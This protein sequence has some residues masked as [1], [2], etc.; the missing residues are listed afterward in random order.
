[1]D[2]LLTI[3]IV[4]YK[5]PEL[6]KICLRL[7]NLHTDLSRVEV[8]VIDNHSED[9]SI[10]WLK[11]LPF[12]KLIERPAMS[13]ERVGESHSRA[14]DLGFEEVKTPLVMVM[15]T[16]TFVMS[17]DWLDVLVKPFEN[18]PNLAG[19]GSWK[20]ES[21]PWWKKIGKAIEDG[22][23]YYLLAPFF[24]RKWGERP[25]RLRNHMFLRSHCAVYRTELLRQYTDG[26]FGGETAGK[27][28]HHQ[29]AEA[30]YELRFIPS[31]E[32]IKYIW[33]LNHATMVLHPEL[34]GKKTSKPS[35]LRQLQ[36]DM[37]KMHYRDILANDKLDIPV[38][39]SSP[40]AGSTP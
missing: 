37:E 12:V 4:Q 31:D 14:L 7:L 13:G 32:L 19:V 8:I 39:R 40:T 24:G 38:T 34:G 30:G 1:M 23:K 9:E 35:S 20:L 29:L 26:F 28:A 5:T 16:D 6:T 22:V 25:E 21:V 11:S 3:L 17:D 10:D 15:H 36:R 2:K 27:K 18:E 33:H